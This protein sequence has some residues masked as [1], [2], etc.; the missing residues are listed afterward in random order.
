[1]PTELA[2]CAYCKTAAC[3]LPWAT[4]RAEGAIFCE[5][6]EQ[7]QGKRRWCRRRAAPVAAST[8]RMHLTHGFNVQKFHHRESGLANF[9]MAR[10]LPALP[11]YA[12]IVS[13]TVEVIGDLKHVSPMAL[14]ALLDARTPRDMCLITDAIAEPYPGQRVRYS[15]DRVAE[16]SGDGKT[17]VVAGTTLLCGSCASML[18]GW[19]HL[20]TTLTGCLGGNRHVQYH[21]GRDRKPR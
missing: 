5:L 8:F 15:R 16:V 9:A 4:M 20:V 12:G 17:V 7:V 1:M 13:P 3:A 18:D 2:G 21:T 11:R 19:R 14:Q 10:A 6:G